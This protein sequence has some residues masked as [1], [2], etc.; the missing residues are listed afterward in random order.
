MAGRG[1]GATLPAWLTEQMASGQLEGLEHMIPHAAVE[2]ANLS[3]QSLNYHN[4][5]AG[6]VT[7]SDKN[8]FQPYEG[9]FEDDKNTNLDKPIQKEFASG[10]D[11]DRRD[12]DNRRERSNNRERDRSRD[13]GRERDRGRDRSKDRR[14][15]SK[16]RSRS[17]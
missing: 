1:R 2:A 4:I 7:Q 10:K 6:N 11:V 8:S 15:R 5:S 14:K 17:R 9:Q 12:R 3:S 16:S 13:R